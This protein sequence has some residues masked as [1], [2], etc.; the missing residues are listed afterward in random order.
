MYINA[1]LV[2]H[3]KLLYDNS[4]DFVFF[5]RRVGIDYEYIYVNKSGA[6]MLGKDVLGDTV[7]GS[8]SDVESATFIIGNYNE[9]I[10][11]N[12]QLEFEDY[13]YFKN[14]VH[15]HETTVT[16]VLYGNEVYVLAVT[17]EIEFDRDMQ[18]K[19]L[20]MRSIFFKT[21]LS[22]ILIKADGTLIEANPMFTDSFGLDVELIRGKK[23]VD[24]PIFTPQSSIQIQQHIERVKKGDHFSS[25]MITFID[26]NQNEQY[27]MATY[28]PIKREEEVTAIFII[29]QDVTKYILQQKELKT[30][31]HGLQT[32]KRAL[33]Y[34]AEMTI[35]NLEGKIIEVNDKFI[36]RTG[37]S[38]EE[39][40]GQT[41]NIVNSNFH[42]QEFFKNL[43]ETVLAGKMW[44]GEVRNR[45]KAGE[46]Y[47]VDTTIIP[48]TNEEGNVY[49][50]ITIHF[51]VSDKKKLMIEL[52]NIERTFR[53]ITEN[54]ND[55]ITV[56]NH[57]GKIVYFSP[58]YIRHLGYTEEELEYLPYKEL[59]HADSLPQWEEIIR[60]GEFVD[61]DGNIELRHLSKTGE[62]IWTEGNYSLV[63]DYVRNTPSQIIMVSR[64]ITERKERE[65]SLMFL[66]YHDS[67]TQLPN[68]RYLQKEF[69]LYVEMANNAFESFAVLY[70]DGDNFKAVND[71]YG[72]EV[73]DEF[74]NHFGKAL[75]KSVRKND[76]VIRVG[77]DEFVIIV[78]NLNRNQEDL[79]RA[80]RKVISNVRSNLQKGWTIQGVNFHPT[81]TIGVSIYPFDG[82]T[83]DELLDFA[84]RA[85]YQA[86]QVQK[87]SEYIPYFEQVKH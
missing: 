49:Q 80:V 14:S 44:R 29:F 48:L 59:L 50:Y 37:Y 36:Q 81:T 4:R 35:T 77:G 7:L 67:L 47:W 74:L 2:D 30:T 71:C 27:Y 46:N 78:G 15:K 16:P 83:I 82:Q 32:F 20:F 40:I 69:P 26:A 11:V 79:E 34:A 61:K 54:T 33:N 65:D 38:R 56:L 42:P 87:N 85:L 10:D 68:R 24:L 28:S 21:F 43:W 51:N 62:V 70:L 84:D 3:L 73:G 18:D 45:T 57:E 8:I 53:L 25:E 41:H 1:D 58:S 23:I 52:R 60:N 9:A 64:E 55:F 63:Y 31:S 17:K 76:L 6:D 22:T 75:L 19:Y 12:D 86:K 5:M 39:L 13:A 72:H 66:A